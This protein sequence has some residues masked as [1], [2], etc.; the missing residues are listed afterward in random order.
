MLHALARDVM[1]PCTFF[2]DRVATRGALGPNIQTRETTLACV[3]RPSSAVR[4]KSFRTSWGAHEERQWH[5]QY[6]CQE[7]HWRQQGDWYRHW[8]QQGDW[9]RHCHQ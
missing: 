6:R 4:G 3:P 7:H 5:R 8:R 9:Y 1:R 2:F